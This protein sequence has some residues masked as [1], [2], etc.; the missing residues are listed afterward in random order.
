MEE[1]N[2]SVSCRNGGCRE[3][4]RW[5]THLTTWMN[6]WKKMKKMKQQPII[7]A[8]QIEK[9]NKYNKKSRKRGK[10]VQDYL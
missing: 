3:Q 10:N 9:K 2:K 6:Q 5:K 4:R 8:N 7:K 1:Q